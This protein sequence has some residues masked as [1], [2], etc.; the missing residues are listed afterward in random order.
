MCRI[1][2]APKITNVEGGTAP[3]LIQYNGES[4]NYDLSYSF[5]NPGE[6]SVLVQDVNGCET[7]VQLATITD[8]P[9]LNIDLV[10]TIEYLEGRMLKSTR[11]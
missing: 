4:F 8:P 5:L 2:G 6:Y 11:I 9:A 10:S 1:F 7:E 3:Y